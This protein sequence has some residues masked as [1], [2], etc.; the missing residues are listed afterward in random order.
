MALGNGLHIRSED[1]PGLWARAPLPA[2]GADRD[3]ANAVGEAIP[4]SMRTENR[5]ALPP[6]DA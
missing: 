1:A 4:R 2:R 3:L 5:R 6:I